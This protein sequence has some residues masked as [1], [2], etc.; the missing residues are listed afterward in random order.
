[1][2]EGD[3]SCRLIEVSPCDLEKKKDF[4]L[5]FTQ[6]RGFF[7]FWKIWRLELKRNNE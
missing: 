6:P 5:Y 4:N 2:D 7:F 3:I 1:M